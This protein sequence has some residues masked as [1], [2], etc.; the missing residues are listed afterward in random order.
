MVCLAEWRAA[1]SDECASDETS[2]D[3]RRVRRGRVQ[4]VE[5]GHGRQ[6]GKEG[7][8]WRF[9]TNT[10]LEDIEETTICCNEICQS[11]MCVVRR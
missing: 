6:R 10:E 11:S 2:G 5:G 4:L 8:T 1:T 9:T 3:E 7:T